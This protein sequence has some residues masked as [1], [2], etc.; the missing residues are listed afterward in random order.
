[1]SFVIFEK[2]TFCLMEGRGLPYD[3]KGQVASFHIDEDNTQI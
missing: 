2:Q 1:M 3:S